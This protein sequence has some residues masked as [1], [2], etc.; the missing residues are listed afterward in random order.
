[1]VVGSAAAVPRCRCSRTTQSRGCSPV[2][3]PSQA[4]ADRSPGVLHGVGRMNRATAHGRAGVRCRRQVPLTYTI[5]AAYG[6][7][8]C[9]VGPC[10]HQHLSVVRVSSRRGAE[11][12][13]WEHRTCRDIRRSRA[14]SRCEQRCPSP[15]TAR[16]NSRP[17]SRGDW[18]EPVALTFRPV[19]VKPRPTVP[20]RERSV[21]VCPICVSAHGHTAAGWEL[22]PL[23]TAQIRQCGHGSSRRGRNLRRR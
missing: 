8:A 6:P 21:T 15:P 12:D 23:I 7:A 5:L 10:P 22:G 11:P 20:R 18:F 16:R 17:L 19:V 14:G 3:P 2:A 1:M 4:F 9:W 13:L